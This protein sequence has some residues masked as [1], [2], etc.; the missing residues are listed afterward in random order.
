M[1]VPAVRKGGRSLG[2][3]PLEVVA[4]LE[5]GEIETVNLME[6]LRTDMSALAISLCSQIPGLASELGPAAEAM[7]GLGVTGRLKV[8]GAAVAKATQARGN[9]FEAVASHRSDIVRQW[10][11]YAV[12]DASLS[13]SVAERLASTMR[14]A[15]DGNMSVRETA[16]LSF[17]PHLPASPDRMVDLL[18]PLTR[19]ASDNIRRFAIEVTRPRSVW[20]AHLSSLK[21]D[22]GLAVQLLDEVMADDSRY[23]RLAV[24]NWLNDAAKSR[25]D[26]VESYCASW[27]KRDH[28]HTRFIIKRGRR[29]L[30]AQELARL[31]SDPLGI[32]MGEA[33]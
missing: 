19:S 3:V 2:A 13:R 20:G 12:N 18:L 10:A 32:T 30:A 15:D 24:G 6:W 27:E 25:P 7:R 31:D 17:R 16:W 33:A 14:F 21:R 22:P 29:T 1:D 28:L 9:D 4:R 23:V 8:A 26:W 11:S 5:A